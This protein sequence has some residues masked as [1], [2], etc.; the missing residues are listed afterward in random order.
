MNRRQF[1][2]AAASLGVG[3]AMNPY[4]SR[5]S[6]LK[7]GANDKIHVGLIGANG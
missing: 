6:G 4:V 3:A 5:A 1:L 2:G 7:V